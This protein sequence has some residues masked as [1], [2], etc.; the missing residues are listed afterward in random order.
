MSEKKAREQRKDTKP[1]PMP[2]QAREQL[3]QLVSQRQQID[4]VITQFLRGLMSGMGMD[5]TYELDMNKFEFVKTDKD[6][7]D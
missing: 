6:T 7:Q 4:A 2:E 1:I 3:K 5:G